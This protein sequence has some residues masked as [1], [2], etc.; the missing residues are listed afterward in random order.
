MNTWGNAQPG[1]L[2]PFNEGRFAIYRAQFTPR[3]GVR[4]SG[5]KMVLRNVVGKAQVWIDGKLAAEKADPAR[6]TLTGRRAGE[7]ERSVN[8]LIEIAAPGT[9]AGLGGTVTVE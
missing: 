9:P 5:G 7:G 8:V 4:R 1:R 3:S 2:T 6:Q